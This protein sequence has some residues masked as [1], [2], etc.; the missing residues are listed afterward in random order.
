MVSINYAVA[1]LSVIIATV[2]RIWLDPILGEGSPFVTYTFSIVFMA[3][4][5]GIGPSFLAMVLG[6]AA[7]KF[8]F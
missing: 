5:G 1:A 4:Y 7:A 8:L 6:F 2:I 3:W